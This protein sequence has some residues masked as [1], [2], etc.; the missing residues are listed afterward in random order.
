MSDD[1]T[2]V[3]RSIY[4]TATLDERLRQE[5]FNNRTSKSELIR[6]YL[7]AGV[8]AGQLMDRPSKAARVT[9]TPPT[10]YLGSNPQGGREL[11]ANKTTA[12]KTSRQ[13]TATR[14]SKSHGNKAKSG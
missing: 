4:L 12:A 10:T 13:Q 8:E 2:L 1:E 14:P 3:L 5:A 6:R 7:E 11:V 9:G